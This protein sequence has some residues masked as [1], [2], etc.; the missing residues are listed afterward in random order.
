[1]KKS[2]QNQQGSVTL[3]YIMILPLVFIMCLFI[4]QFI[5]AG[6]AVWETQYLVREGIRQ[7]ASDRDVEKEEERGKKAFPSDGNF[8]LKDYKVQMKDGQVIA[9]AITEIDAVFLPLQP[10]EY[11]YTAKTPLID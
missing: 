6:M 11:T 2:L 1:M 8:R 5:V 9:T 4:W 3:E 7:A 10:F